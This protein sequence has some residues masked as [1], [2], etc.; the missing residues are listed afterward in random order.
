MQIVRATAG[1][2]WW[3]RRVQLQASETSAFYKSKGFQ[4]TQAKIDQN[5]TAVAF[6]RKLLSRRF[7]GGP[8]ST[9]DGGVV[10]RDLDESRDDCHSFATSLQRLISS[11]FPHGPE[12]APICRTLQVLILT[13]ILKS[14][15]VFHDQ[16]IESQEEPYGTSHLR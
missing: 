14:K 9:S 16:E 7:N 3:P 11:Q 1:E 12:V 8:N 6:P 10:K 5:E 2:Q 13:A 4:G 15:G